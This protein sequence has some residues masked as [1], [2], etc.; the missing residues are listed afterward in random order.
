[1]GQ[2][3]TQGAAD[4]PDS[5][6]RSSRARAPRFRHTLTVIPSRR[7]HLLVRNWPRRTGSRSVLRG[8]LSALRCAT[9]PAEARASC[10][11]RRT[12]GSFSSSCAVRGNVLRWGASPARS[13]SRRHHRHA[14]TRSSSCGR[15]SPRQPLDG[16]CAHLRVRHEVFASSER[17]LRPLGHAG[18]HDGSRSS[19]FS[20]SSSSACTSCRWSSRSGTRTC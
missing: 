17:L 2:S 19:T 4:D 8:L 16:R 9:G 3:P 11:S 20:T 14:S 6:T 5:S 18:D 1:M 12:S 13:L 7:P 10:A 15:S